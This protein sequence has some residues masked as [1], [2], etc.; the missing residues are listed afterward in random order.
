MLPRFSH[1]IGRDGF[2]IGMLLYLK[3]KLESGIMYLLFKRSGQVLEPD[4]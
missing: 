2:D 4:C 3:Q 1:L